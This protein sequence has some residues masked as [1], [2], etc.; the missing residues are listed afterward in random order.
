MNLLD[1]NVWVA[2]VWNGHPDHDKAVRWR[3]AARPPYAM[4]RVTQMALLRLLSNGAVLG[5]AVQTRRAAWKL[6]LRQIDDPEVAWLDE[7]VG[8]EDA[9]RK[10]S[11]RDE[12]HHKLWTDDYLAALAQ[13]SGATLVTLDRALAQRYPS[14]NVVTL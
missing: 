11:A 5:Q 1:A 10:L 13:T 2:G 8:L 7:P 12:T 3:A 4:C 9:W 6:V 14:V